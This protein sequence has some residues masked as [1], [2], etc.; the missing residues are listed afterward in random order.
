M[1]FRPHSALLAVACACG[2]ADRPTLTVVVTGLVAATGRVVVTS[3][4]RPLFTCEAGTCTAAV[5]PGAALSLT[6]APA[7]LSRFMGWSGGC[8]GS[9]PDCRL[10]VADAGVSVTA[11][12]APDANFAFTSSSPLPMPFGATAD[13]AQK[14]ADDHCNAHA[15][16]A[17]L[18]G[19]YVAWL[20]TSSKNAIAKLGSANGWIRTDGRPFANSQAD[21]AAG[22]IFYPPVLAEDGHDVGATS[23][24]ASGTDADGTALAGGTCDDWTSTA[25]VTQ[26]TGVPSGG[27][28][29]WTAAPYKWPCAGP[30][31]LYCFE[32]S[33]NTPVVAAAT[34]RIAFVSRAF[35]AP[36]PG[37]SRA[38][39]D[40]ICQSEAL[41][42]GLPGDYLA[43]LAVDGE[44]PLARFSVDAGLPW[45]RPDG[46]QLVTAA[47]R[48]VDSRILAPIDVTADKTYVAGGS[49]WTGSVG[50]NVAGDLAGTCN[51]WGSTAGSGDGGQIEYTFFWASEYQSSISCE[52]AARVY[53][54]EK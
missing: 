36:A 24:A 17:S 14:A 15:A 46:V 1:S 16:S 40:A 2:G 54:F 21:L 32:V 5:E 50:S 31:A 48:I 47:S 8:R 53:C 27:S 42:A 7:N 22:R 39:A 3:D 35:F 33:L 37:K 52:A 19:H 12:F 23:Y 51:N 10:T 43:L 26:G 30:F 29:A 18:P 28:R 9:A 34:G 11:R 44:P 13:A 4:G 45:V 49:T 20:S 25:G 41:A 6:T 38:N